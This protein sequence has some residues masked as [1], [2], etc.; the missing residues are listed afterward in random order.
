MAILGWSSGIDDTGTGQDGTVL[1]KAFFDGHEA[2]V[3]A[4]LISPSNPGV[5]AANVIDEVV[6]ARGTMPLLDDRLDVSLNEDGTLKAAAVQGA[7]A[8]FRNL[9]LVNLLGNDTFLIWPAGNVLAP[10]YWALSGVGSAIQRTGSGLADGARKHGPFAAR[11]TSGGGAAAVLTQTLIAA[12]DFGMTALVGRFIAFGVRARTGSAGGATAKFFDGVSSTFSNLHSGSLT[13][14]PEGDGWEWLFGV[15]QVNAGATT[16]QILLETS[17]GGTIAYWS[18]AAAVLSDTP[19]VD[20]VPALVTRR[21]LKTFIPGNLTVGNKWYWPIER[22]AIVQNISAMFETA[23]SGTAAVL[24]FDSWDGAAYTTM[25]AAGLSITATQGNS[26]SPPGGTFARR[27]LDVQ[28]GTTRRTGGM[29]RFRVTTDD[30]GNTGA[31]LSVA[32]DYDTYDRLFDQ[33]RQL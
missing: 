25:L 16:L 24:D 19:P 12:G 6:D 30:G 28:G 18:G 15:H 9:S 3:E 20:W 27:C 8:G 29:V 14:G 13:G 2:A 21:S 4:L 11:V 1:N 10:S 26:I 33:I 23:P 22:P 17:S 5:S 31:D 7:L 32:I